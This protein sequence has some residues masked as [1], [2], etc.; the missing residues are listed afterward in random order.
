MSSALFTRRVDLRRFEGEIVKIFSQILSE[1]VDDVEILL[2]KGDFSTRQRDALVIVS[3]LNDGT[4]LCITPK[5][6]PEWSIM[7]DFCCKYSSS[8]D[9]SLLFFDEEY[10][11]C[12]KVQ[13]GSSKESIEKLIKCDPFCGEREIK[14]PED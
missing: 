9:Y 14:E 6:M 4:S 11:F 8:A 3:L 2:S 7:I 13:P 1:T 5:G 10:S 12:V